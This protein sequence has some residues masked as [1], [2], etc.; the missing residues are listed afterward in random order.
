MQAVA[1]M[2]N[3]SGPKG[4]QPAGVDATITQPQYVELE[5]RHTVP[6]VDHGLDFSL[7]RTG[8][9][10]LPVEL[11]S[12]R[13]RPAG[14]GCAFRSPRPSMAPCRC[15]SRSPAAASPMCGNPAWAIS[16]RAAMNRGRRPTWPRGRR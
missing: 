2:V 12:G 13:C 10:T 15:S 7:V 5:L 16:A 3:K 6:A 4:T 1:P 14:I 11:L 9:R 8:N